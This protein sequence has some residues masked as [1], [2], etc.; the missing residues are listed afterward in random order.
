VLGRACSSKADWRCHSS[1][2]VKYGIVCIVDRWVER[3][4]SQSHVSRAVSPTRRRGGAK[5]WYV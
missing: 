1:L 5:I 4:H 2:D 3:S